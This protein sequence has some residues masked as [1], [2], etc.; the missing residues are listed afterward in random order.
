MFSWFVNYDIASY[1]QTLYALLV[2]RA[3]GMQQQHVQ[4]VF[5]ATAVA[6]RIYSA[7]SWIGYT[8]AADRERIERF[9]RR[10]KRFGYYAPSGE[11]SAELGSAA[12]NALFTRILADS[13]HSLHNLL[14][15]KNQSYGVYNLRSWRYDRVQPTHATHYD[16]IMI[17]N[18]RC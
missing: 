5:S 13:N 2:M 15:P 6:K 17:K 9:L 16:D 8:S 3:H 7:S 1:E 14:P 10:S 12:D 11:T 4:T 18:N